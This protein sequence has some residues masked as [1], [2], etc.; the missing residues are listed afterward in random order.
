M[1]LSQLFT[2]NKSLKLILGKSEIY[3]PHPLE[4]KGARLRDSKSKSMHTQKI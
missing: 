1:V 4:K 2:R 3:P